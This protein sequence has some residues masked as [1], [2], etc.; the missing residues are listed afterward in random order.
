MSCSGLPGSVVPSQLEHPVRTRQPARLVKVMGSPA[1]PTPDGEG[2]SR[3]S[4]QPTCCQRA[5]VDRPPVE[6]R[7]LRPSEHR[8]SPEALERRRRIAV[9]GSPT[10]S[11]RTVGAVP[12]AV[13]DCISL[14][15]R[16]LIRA[17]LVNAR[18]P[19][20]VVHEHPMS[21]PPSEGSSRRHHEHQDPFHVRRT[22]AAASKA[23]SAFHRPIPQ[24]SPHASARLAS[25]Q[26][27]PVGPI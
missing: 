21:C 10:S 9:A 4:L 15:E 22:N 5:P 6:P 24:A 7:G 18:E 11:G 17:R 2:T 8:S 20:R 26:V 1:S 13:P 12:P 3:L 25:E 27:L 14:T 16:S 23:R 19:R